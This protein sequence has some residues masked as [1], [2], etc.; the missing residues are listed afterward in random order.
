M[1]LTKKILSSLFSIAILFSFVSIT[2]AEVLEVRVDGDPILASKCTPVEHFDEEL[3]TK[4]QNIKDTFLELP[5]GAGLAATQVGYTVRFFVI[6]QEAEGE[7]I[8]EDKQLKRKPDQPLVF[9]NPVIKET[10]GKQ[11][12]WE[13]CFSLP[14]YIYK[15]ERP[16]NITIEAL[17]ENDKKFIFKTTGFWAKC[18]HHEN[19]HLD[20]VLCK[21]NALE[22]REAP[23]DE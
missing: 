6:S 19:D 18:I 9:I 17:D 23:K 15:T 16:L 14:G 3:K 7:L 12:G 21:T 13:S 10:S 1:R 8:Y 20:G 11:I 2:H 4:I 22:I 5:N